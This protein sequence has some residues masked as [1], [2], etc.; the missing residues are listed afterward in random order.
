MKTILVP[1]DFTAHANA[2]VQLAS[3]IAS[4]TGSPIALLHNVSCLVN[5]EGLSEEER[6]RQYELYSKTKIGE[7]KLNDLV[8]GDLDAELNVSKVVTHGITYSEIVNKAE[9]LNADMI[10][11]GSHGHEGPDR[12]FIGSNIQKVIRFAKCPVLAAK[13]AL[14]HKSVKKIVFPSLFDFDVHK[15]FGEVVKLATALNAT[16]YLLYVNTPAKFKDSFVIEQEMKEF[17]DQYPNLKFKCG[18]Y[19]HHDAVEGMLEYCREI[20]ADM[21]ALVTRDRRHSPKYLV[22][23]TE[24]VASQADIPVLS[25]NEK[26]F[27]PVLE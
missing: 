9:Q 6:H 22:G 8:S 23:I 21:I 16:I 14:P 2:G 7:R 18:I 27:E 11:M 25:V 3:Q 26:I 19:D 24:L 5:W 1:T 15:P 10:I 13:N 4:Q 12:V 17:C 20:D